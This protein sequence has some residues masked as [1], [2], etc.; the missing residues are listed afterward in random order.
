MTSYFLS[1][2]SSWS[3]Q[4]EVLCFCFGKRK[5]PHYFH[6][7]SAHQQR[8]QDAPKASTKKIKRLRQAASRGA[9]QAQYD[10]AAFLGGGALALSSTTPNRTCRL[11]QPSRR[12][13]RR[14]CCSPSTTTER[15]QRTA[16]STT[17]RPR[18]RCSASARRAAAPTPR[19]ASARATRT[20]RASRRARGLRQGLTILFTQPLNWLLLT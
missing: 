4:F 18:S 3:K 15:A 17:R 1:S 19:T 5:Q 14:G 13:T 9:A 11:G 8:W 6:R 7:R 2:I 20:A 10:L 16:T 12:A